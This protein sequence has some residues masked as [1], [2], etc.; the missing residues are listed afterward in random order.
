MKTTVFRGCD[1]DRVAERRD[2]YPTLKEERRA[3][4]LI[5]ELKIRQTQMRPTQDERR[6]PRRPA[7][8]ASG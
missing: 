4:Q 7:A 2:L 1:P 5:K 8:P 6:E 3:Q